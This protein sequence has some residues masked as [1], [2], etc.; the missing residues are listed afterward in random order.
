[1]STPER[2]ATACTQSSAALTSLRLW[3]TTAARS[4]DGIVDPAVELGREP[5]A[6]VGFEAEDEFTVP[7]RPGKAGGYDAGDACSPAERRRRDLVQDAP[8]HVRTPHAAL[9]PTR[10]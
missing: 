10:A 9:A 6:V 7:L 5:R 4:T 3:T 2:A 1:S 8:V